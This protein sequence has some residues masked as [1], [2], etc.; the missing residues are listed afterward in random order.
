MVDLQKDTENLPTVSLGWAHSWGK[1]HQL[2]AS[3][4]PEGAGLWSSHAWSC[5]EHP[6]WQHW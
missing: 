1:F 3:K 2:K 5:R 4:A 6:P